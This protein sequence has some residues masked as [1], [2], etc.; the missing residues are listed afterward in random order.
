MTATLSFKS[1]SAAAVYRS[2]GL[3]AWQAE[4]NSAISL[5]R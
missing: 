2:E 5:Y 1:Q 4:K 3:C